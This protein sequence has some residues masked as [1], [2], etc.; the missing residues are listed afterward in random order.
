MDCT[1]PSLLLIASIILVN[2]HKHVIVP[3]SIS[4]TTSPSFI[5]LILYRRDGL[6]ILLSYS[7]KR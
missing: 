3:S 5:P 2:F 6:F 4:M 7:L 1:A